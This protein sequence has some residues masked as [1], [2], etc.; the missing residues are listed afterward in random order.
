MSSSSA[1]RQGSK[2]PNT[3]VCVKPFDAK[4]PK[5]QNLKKNVFVP[6]INVDQNMEWHQIP[7]DIASQTKENILKSYEETSTCYIDIQTD[8]LAAWKEVEENKENKRVMIAS[9]R[10][11]IQNSEH[12]RSTNQ[13]LQKELEQ[14][15]DNLKASI[16]NAQDLHAWAQAK[17][18]E[19]KDLLKTNAGLSTEIIEMK[20]KLAEKEI[21]IAKLHENDKELKCNSCDA[22]FKKEESL[23]M[24][25]KVHEKVASLLDPPISAESS[26]ESKKSHN[27]L[28]CHICKKGFITPGQLKSHIASVH[29]RKSSYLC[30]RCDSKIKLF[31]FLPFRLITS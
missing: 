10:E 20:K 25:S 7:F 26:V 16:E 2:K 23:K 29:D 9:N 19:N 27:I 17:D 31:H 12:M 13:K 24:H 15:Q 21:E 11:I 22:F 30:E 3:S 1:D 14:K 18:E 5:K 6:Q 28:D 4:V 8:L